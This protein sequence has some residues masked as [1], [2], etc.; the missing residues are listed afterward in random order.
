MGEATYYMKANECD[1]AK[2]TKI[3]E[4]F[5]EG[6]LTEDWW[7]GHRGYEDNKSPEMNREAFWKIFT[8]KF[9]LV[10]KYLKFIELYGGDC[11]N[12]LAGYLEFGRDW[13]I[14]ENFELEDNELRY[15]ALVWHFADWDGLMKYLMKEFGVTNARYISDEYYDPFD[16]L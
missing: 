16:G 9:P 3:Q 1:Y 14:D 13:E 8:D 12:S 10:T 7:Q 5:K 15:H 2:M 6:R 11:N 4:F